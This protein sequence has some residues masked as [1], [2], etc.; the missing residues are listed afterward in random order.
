MDAFKRC[1]EIYGESGRARVKLDML[2]KEK[3]F[4]ESLKKLADLKIR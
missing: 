2:V 1:Y 4:Q 3:A